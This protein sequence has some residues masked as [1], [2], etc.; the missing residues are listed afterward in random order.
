MS[1][2]KP[3]GEHGPL[4]SCSDDPGARGGK[5][6]SG[7]VPGATGGN[8]CT[9]PPGATSGVAGS[10][11]SVLLTLLLG[12]IWLDGGVVERSEFDDNSP[13]DAWRSPMNGRRV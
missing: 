5:A 8:S 6:W 11:P 4:C 13:M 10:E 12:L 3:D 9:V 7:G 1:P 2:A